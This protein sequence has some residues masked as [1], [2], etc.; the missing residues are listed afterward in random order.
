M[1]ESDAEESRISFVISTNGPRISV[2]EKNNKICVVCRD[3]LLEDGRVNKDMLKTSKEK[4]AWEEFE[5]KIAYGVDV[6]FLFTW[7]VQIG[8]HSQTKY[9]TS[10]DL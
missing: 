4:K 9:P 10:D 6:K 1:V 7:W 5:A 8:I 2:F 3:D